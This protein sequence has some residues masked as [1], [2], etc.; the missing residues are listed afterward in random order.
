M[1]DDLTSSRF[2]IK[3]QSDRRTLIVDY[4][5][6]IADRLEEAYRV[7]RKNNKVGKE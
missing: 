3:G 1:E 5:D 4:I 2:L 6:A 7:V